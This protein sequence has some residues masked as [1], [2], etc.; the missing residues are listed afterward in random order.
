MSQAN[1]HHRH[2]AYDLGLG[3]KVISLIDGRTF[4]QEIL[5][6]HQALWGGI[7][8]LYEVMH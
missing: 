6:G 5:L 3:W 7:P 1:F 8:L 4:R 2:A